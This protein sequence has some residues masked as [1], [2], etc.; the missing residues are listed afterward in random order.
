MPRPFGELAR[1]IEVVEGEIEALEK[2]IEDG[3]SNEQQ[4]YGTLMLYT[5]LEDL[6]RN[7]ETL[8]SDFYYQISDEETHNLLKLQIHILRQFT[9]L[10]HVPK[11]DGYEALAH[12]IS[13]THMAT[14]YNA[15]LVAVQQISW[16]RAKRFLLSSPDQAVRKRKVNDLVKFRP[17]ISRQHS[18][19]LENN[20]NL[21]KQLLPKMV[22]L[23]RL[24]TSLSNLIATP[25]SRQEVEV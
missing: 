3:F 21:G 15:I 19:V 5:A 22:E 11:A 14:V 4:L 6:L 25:P 23:Q 10:H 12:E 9:G 8:M 18:K 17:D 13:H 24:V 7:N 2:Q 20:R 1:Q 16:N